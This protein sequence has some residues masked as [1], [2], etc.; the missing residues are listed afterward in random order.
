MK[1]SIISAILSCLLL[2]AFALSWGGV[3]DNNTRLTSDKDFK[4]L[5]LSQSNGVHLSFNAPFNTDGSVKLV[6]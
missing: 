2:P 4:Q 6:G 3:V 5:G 1:K